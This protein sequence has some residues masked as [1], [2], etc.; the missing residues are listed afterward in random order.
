MVEAATDTPALAGSC[1]TSKRVLLTRRSQ[2]RFHRWLAH[3]CLQKQASWLWNLNNPPVLV[4]PG[5]ACSPGR[6]CSDKDGVGM[7]ERNEATAATETAARLITMEPILAVRDVSTAANYYRDVLDFAD[8]WL[9]GEPPTHGG[10]NRDGV[11]LQFSLNPTLAETAEGREIWIRV[12]DVR[13]MYALH[14]ERGAEIVATLEPKPWGVSEYTVRDLNGYRLRFAGS[15]GPREASRDLPAEVRIESRL[16]T[17]PEME[18]LIHAVGW[19]RSANFETAPRVLEMA[20]CGAVALVE[21]QAVG[22]AFLT[23]DN[24]GLYYVRDVIVHSD[25]QGRRIGTALMQVLMEY[26][27]AHAPEGALVGLYTG[28]HLHDFYAQFGFRGPNSGLYG[29]TQV[30]QGRRK[31]SGG[32]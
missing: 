19:A 5:Q 7:T 22:C 15:G 21:G 17:W 3:S 12:R 20:L 9:W 13:S 29:M 10:A 4:D 2:N 11:A 18:T 1:A 31:A 32:E 14:Q 24:A 27:R 16:P 23:G 30:L 28:S 8:V 6:M 25:W 26:L